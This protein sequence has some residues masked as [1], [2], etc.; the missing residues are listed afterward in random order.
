ME[1]DMR[2]TALAFILFALPGCF[3]LKGG[4]D[5]CKHDAC[6]GATAVRCTSVKESY[7]RVS[8]EDCPEGNTCVMR[9]NGWAECVPR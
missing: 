2:T 9:E 8:R 3:I 6:D 7:N 4:H 1:P 5:E